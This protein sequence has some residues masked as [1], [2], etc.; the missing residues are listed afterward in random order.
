M[1]KTSVFKIKKINVSKI[2]KAYVTTPRQNEFSVSFIAGDFYSFAVTL[3]K[4]EFYSNKRID[5]IL[6]RC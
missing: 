5:T 3:H 2:T 6:N 1:N 4:K